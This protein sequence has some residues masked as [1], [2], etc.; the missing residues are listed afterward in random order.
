[1]KTIVSENQC[2]Q[3]VRLAERLLPE[4]TAEGDKG[5]ELI[6]DIIPMSL[7]GGASIIAKYEPQTPLNPPERFDRKSIINS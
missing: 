1:M 4:T 6:V 5:S 3:Q 2:K 7:W